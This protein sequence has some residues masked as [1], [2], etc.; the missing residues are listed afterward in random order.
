MAG[1]TDD[2]M[3]TV[4]QRN[5]RWPSKGN[6]WGPLWKA[7]RR[8]RA[9]RGVS[10]RGPRRILSR[11]CGGRAVTVF[12]AQEGWSH[13]SEKEDGKWRRVWRDVRNPFIGLSSW[14][15]GKESA[16]QAGDAGSILGSGR[17]PGEGNGNPLQYS[18]LGKSMDRGAWRATVHWVAKSDTT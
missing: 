5:Q 14:L 6:Q 1:L 2:E 10:A 15:S 9:G 11:A 4:G 13:C 8:L 12:Q 7:E 16:S 3:W 17:S 18:C